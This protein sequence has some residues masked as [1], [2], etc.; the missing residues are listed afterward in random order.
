M[1]KNVKTRRH[2]V[3]FL[4]SPT[5]LLVIGVGV[6]VVV[7]MAHIFIESVDSE[8]NFVVIPKDDEVSGFDLVHMDEI[9]Y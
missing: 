8:H 3:F 9:F 1:R 4:S 6:R 7:T 5:R 2:M